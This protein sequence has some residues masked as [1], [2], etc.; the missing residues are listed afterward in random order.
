MPVNPAAASPV[1]ARSK[2]LGASGSRVSGTWRI[3]TQITTAASG[4]LMTKISRHDTDW[5][6]QPP[7]NGPIA[8]VMPAKPDHA[9]IAAARSWRRKLAS[10]IAR[11]PGVSSAPPTP[12]NARARMRSPDVG[13]TAHASDA[14]ANHTTPTTK[15]RRRPSRSPSEPPKRRNA[16]KVNVYALTVHCRLVNPPPRSAPIRGSAMLTT[17]ASS[18]AIPE[19]RIVATTTQRPRADFK[20][21]SGAVSAIFSSPVSRRGQAYGWRSSRPRAS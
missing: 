5:I 9:P 17:V 7:T 6:S 16:A 21:S 4:T 3:V 1:P 2:R 19:P 13:A 15:M 14:T 8:V 11:L 20:T 18:D 10:R 12:W